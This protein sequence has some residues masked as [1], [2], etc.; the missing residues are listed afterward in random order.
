MHMRSLLRV[1][2]SEPSETIGSASDF[3]ASVGEHTRQLYRKNQQ[4]VAPQSES[5]LLTRAELLIR[6]VC[7]D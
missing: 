5:F 7:H 6:G 1:L 2:L 4:S 3:F